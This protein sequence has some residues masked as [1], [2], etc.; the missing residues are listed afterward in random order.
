MNNYLKNA[1]VVP[2]FR[3]SEE[4]YKAVARAIWEIF[5]KEKSKTKLVLH[6]VFN[7]NSERLLNGET[8][9]NFGFIDLY[10][11][12][13]ADVINQAKNYLGML[14]IDQIDSTKLDSYL[15][16]RK[17]QKNEGLRD[18]ILSFKSELEQGH[19]KR[20]IKMRQL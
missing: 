18:Y 17:I 3:E 7:G 10:E 8:L 11:R 5:L 14:A 4:N 13:E 2:P 19:M 20:R 9:R 6:L 12:Y 15:K 1:V 16:T